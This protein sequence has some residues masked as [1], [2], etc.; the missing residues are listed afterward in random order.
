MQH[1]TRSALTL[2]AI[3][4]SAQLSAAPNVVTSIK[5]INDLV[6]AVMDGVGEPTRLIPPGSSPHTYALKPSER[7]AAEHA[8]VLFWIGPEV[9]TSLEKVSQNLPKQARVVTLADLPGMEKLQARTGGDWERKRPMARQADAHG[10]HGDHDEHN[11]RS[12]LDGHMWLSPA[13]AGVIVRATAQTLSEIDPT[14]T[15]KYQANAEQAL[16]RLSQLDTS[17]KQQLA[18]VQNKPFIVFH[19]AYQY[20]EHA[21]DLQAAG[22]ILVSPDAMA[23][24]KRVN[25]MRNKIKALGATCVF[26]EPQ[27]E[28]KLVQTLVEGTQ[29]RTGVLDPLG[30]SL[31]GGMDGYEQL[32]QN[33]ANNLLHCLQ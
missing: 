5:P 26:S 13:N 22:S 4:F 21:Y 16:T 12:T 6:L 31:P 23:S 1:I 18:P 3:L 7:Q 24:A 10:K 14:N 33:L 8:D 20:F 27:F 28:P 11:H 25:D 9:E 30:A 17:L 32:I 29:A 2:I 19:D 15:A